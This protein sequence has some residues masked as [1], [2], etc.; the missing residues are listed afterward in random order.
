MSGLSGNQEAG[1]TQRGRCGTVYGSIGPQQVAWGRVLTQDPIGHK[2]AVPLDLLTHRLRT[3]LPA[4]GN[5]LRL[6][7]EEIYAVPAVL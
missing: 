2:Q 5:M 7:G 1:C 3:R 6:R 4:L